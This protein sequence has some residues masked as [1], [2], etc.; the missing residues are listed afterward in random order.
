MHV[1]QEKLLRLSKEQNLGKFKLREIGRL[2]GEKSPQ[3]VKHHLLQLERKGLIRTDRDMIQPVESGWVKGFATS[4]RLFSIPILGSANCGP[5]ALF[6]EENVEGYLRVSST[7]L[8][9]KNPRNFFALRARGLSM[10]RANV[11]GKNI[12]DGDY[13][14][15][16]S[17]HRTPKN[18]DVVVSV[19]DG[20]ANIKKF[21]LDEENQQIALL[22]EST[23]E[24]SPIYIHEED[25]YL[26]NGKVVQIIKKP[27]PPK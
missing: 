14:I 12:E 19:I 18:G 24:F 25:D 5:A 7:L 23:R 6:A 17:E 1:I 20:V 27:K 8:G 10:N 26:V 3:K 16:D 9:P 22:S 13:L 15:I 2:I 11:D 4:A 21:V